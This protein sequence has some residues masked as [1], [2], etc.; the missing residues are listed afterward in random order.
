MNLH[1][2]A[3]LLTI[4][5]PPYGFIEGRRRLFPPTASLSPDT[6]H[7]LYGNP[8]GTASIFLQ[9]LIG[10]KSVR[11]LGQT[12]RNYVSESGNCQSFDFVKPLAFDRT[13]GPPLL[14]LSFQISKKWT[15]Q[16]E[17]AVVGSG[18]T[19]L[20]VNPGCRR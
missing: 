12:E 19:L 14:S 7:I 16:S 11:P 18:F 2:N 15:T 17:R 9:S 13:K 5:Q 8:H 3:V 4:L 20:A 6:A 1:S 10:R